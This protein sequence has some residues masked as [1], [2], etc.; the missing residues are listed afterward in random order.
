MQIFM[1]YPLVAP[2]VLEPRR[3]QFCIAYDV[4][5]VA[6]PEICLQRPGVD[7]IIRELKGASVLEHVRVNRHVEAGARG[8]GG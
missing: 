3:R 6:M 4:L 2:E 7:A 5:N 1:R 8:M